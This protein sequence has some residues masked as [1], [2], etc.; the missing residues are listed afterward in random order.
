[1]PKRKAIND[2]SERSLK[3]QKSI[4][5][6]GEKRKI[7]CEIYYISSVKQRLRSPSPVYICSRH[8]DDK[9]ICIIYD[10]SGGKSDIKSSYNY[11]N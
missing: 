6:K 4:H 2:I 5:R 3:V 11:I 10:C 9:A 8:E 1:M 7:S